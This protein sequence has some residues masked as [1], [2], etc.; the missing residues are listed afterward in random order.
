M[1]RPAEGWRLRK[2]RKRFFVRFTHAGERVELA[3]GS[4][5]PEEAARRAAKLYADYHANTSKRRLKANDPAAPILE[6]GALWLAEIEPEVD[7]GTLGTLMGY[8]RH[9]QRFFES[10]GR[11]TDAACL[12]Y[13][14]ERLTRVKRQTIKKELGALRR[15]VSWATAHGLFTRAPAVPP[16]P[17]RAAGTP[18]E[19]RRRDKATPLTPE[20][21][22]AIIAALPE[23]SSSKR[24]D[25]FAV[26]ARFRLMWE[27]A[28]R[29]KTIDRLSV[30]ENYVPGATMLV[31]TQAIDKTRFARELPLTAAARDALESVCPDSGVI[32]GR[33]EYRDQLRRAA[34]HALSPEKAKTFT[35]YDLRHARA[36]QWAESGNLVGVAYLLGHKQITTTNRYARPNQAAAARVLGVK[37]SAVS[38]S[39]VAVIS[40]LQFA[41]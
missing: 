25:R 27:T 30:P 23:W 38:L 36:T 6:V 37:E 32:F 17:A 2:R 35:A 24:V 15:F 5:D 14:R 33:H 34:R 7:P 1:A 10:M 21:V 18:F 31:I 39:Y 22:E 26:R 16:L 41:A 20:E 4:S 28:L 9:F 29:P 3:T 19:K 11:I 8:V 12:A 40:P 13:M